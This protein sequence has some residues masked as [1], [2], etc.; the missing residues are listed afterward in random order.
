MLHAPAL[1]VSDPLDA[2]AADTTA[3]EPPLPAL[4]RW[5]RPAVDFVAGL[6]LTIHRKLLAGFLT[7]ALLL[8]AMAALS[9]V[10]IA[11]MDERMEVLETQARKVDL[12]RQ[13]LYDVTAQSHY[14]AMA[15]L[16]ADDDQAEAARWN[17]RGGGR[18]RTISQA[19]ERSGRPGSGERRVLR[20]RC[21]RR[22]RATTPRATRW[23]RRSTT[24]TDR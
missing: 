12:A 9:L 22:T 3:I 15:L 7:G 8:V 14:R 13:M 1:E 17:E 21:V 2:E 10:V 23:S 16:E 19:P 4:T 24:R 5:L 11:R 6:R 18:G 20:R